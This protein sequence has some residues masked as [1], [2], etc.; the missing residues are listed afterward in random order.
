M[1]DTTMKSQYSFCRIESRPTN[2]EEVFSDVD[3]LVSK[4]H[5]SIYGL[6]KSF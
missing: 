6:P 3:E 4:V 5:N 2:F 1:Y